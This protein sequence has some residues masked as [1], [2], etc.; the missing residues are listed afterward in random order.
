MVPRR[1]PRPYYQTAPPGGGC[2]A[3]PVQVEALTPQQV[4][5]VCITDTLSALAR[6]PEAAGADP[7]GLAWSAM[8]CT[9]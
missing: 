8:C 6:D 4:R 5:R 7:T 1:P 3:D 9:V 2:R